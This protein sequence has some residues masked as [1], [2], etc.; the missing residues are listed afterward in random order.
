MWKDCDPQGCSNLVGDSRDGTEE[1]GVGGGR[2][3]LWLL[4][5][6][7]GQRSNCWLSGSLGT[8]HESPSIGHMVMDWLG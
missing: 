4:A 8:P 3:E 2:G 1:A 6:R 5:R 7:G